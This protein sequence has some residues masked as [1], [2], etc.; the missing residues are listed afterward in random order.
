MKKI[1]RFSKALLVPL[2]IF[3]APFIASA[4]VTEPPVTAPQNIANIDQIL[5]SQVFCTLINW[6]FWLIIVLAVIF[7]LVAGFRYLFAAGDP[8][9]VKVAGSSLLYVIVAIIIALIA[10]G[11]PTIISSL[12]G[13]GL[14]GIGC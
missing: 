12:V 10:K 5:N 14:N 8:E 13:G 6:V 9:K 4:Q 3:A 2:A 11:F 7:T 1:L